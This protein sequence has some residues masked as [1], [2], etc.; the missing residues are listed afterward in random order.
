MFEYKIMTTDQPTATEE[1]LNG[2][3]KD[4]WELVPIFRYDYLWYYYFKRMVAAA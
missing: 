1:Q 2:Y 3:G 4:G